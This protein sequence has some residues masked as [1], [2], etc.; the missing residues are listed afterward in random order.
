VFMFAG[1]FPFL[2]GVPTERMR[3]FWELNR[4][5]NVIAGQLLE[6]T[7]REKQ[8][9]VAEELTDKSVIGLLRMLFI[10]IGWETHFRV[11]YSKG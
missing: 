11:Q 5:L 3:L 9:N 2:L 8:G 10:P 7:R 1:K 6:N 4:S